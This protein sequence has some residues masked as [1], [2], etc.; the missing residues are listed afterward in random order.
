M[1]KE[2]RTENESVLSISVNSVGK[3]QICGNAEQ[4]CFTIIITRKLKL[5]TFPTKAKQ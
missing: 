4:K 3:T 2:G 1:R 5:A